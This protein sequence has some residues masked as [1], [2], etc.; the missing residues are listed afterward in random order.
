MKTNQRTDVTAGFCF[1]RRLLAVVAVCCL[2]PQVASAETLLKSAVGEEPPHP[3]AAAE[4]SLTKLTN[5]EPPYPEEVE[6]EEYEWF[7][8]HSLHGEAFNEGPRQAARLMEGVGAIRF[9][10]TSEIPDVQRFIEQGIGQTHGYWY[11][12]AERSFRQAAMLDP[13]CAIAYW[14]MALA[15]ANNSKR[16]KS[17]IAEAVARKEN[18]SEREQ[19]YIDS[20]DGYLNSKKKTKEKSIDYFKAVRKIVDAYPGDLEAKALY[21]YLAYRRRTYVGLSMEEAHDAIGAVLAVEPKHPVHHYRI[22]LWDAK[23]PER[24][25][26]SAARCGQAAPN[27]A[28]MW[29]MPGHI[30][31]RLKRYEDA[32]WQQEASARTDH[33]NMIRDGVMPDEIHNFAHNNE[34]LIRNLI[35]IGRWQDAVSLAVNMT[36]LPRHPKNNKLTG[37]GSASYGRTRLFSVLTEFELWERLIELSDEPALE[38]TEIK[39][40][41]LKRLRHR[42]IAF[43]NL[44]EIAAATQVISELHKMGKPIE[45]EVDALK[46]KEKNPKKPSSALKKKQSELDDYI[47]AIA[48]VEGYLAAGRYEY[49]D[50]AALLKKGK[51]PESAIARCRLLAGDVDGALKAAHSQ[52]TSNQHE[53]I[54]AAH[55]VELLWLAG[56]QSE[57]KQ[58]FEKLREESGSIQMGSPVFDRL[59]PIA[60]ANK[61]PA[62]WIKPSKKAKDLGVRPELNKLGPFRWSPQQAPDWSR[63]NADNQQVSN[64]DYANR[65]VL[66]VFYLGFGCLHCVE[67]LKALS[68]EADKFKEAGIDIVA[69][70]SEDLEG[71]KISLKNYEG[72]MPFPLLADPD[73]S[74]FKK[75]RAY[76]DFEELPLHGAFLIDSAG[77]IRWRDTGHE[78]FMDVKFLLK[79]SKRLLAQSPDPNAEVKIA[80]P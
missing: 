18:A 64:A 74:V 71:L 15:N 67:Q 75:F 45:R 10:V 6:E 69:I 79:E 22:H 2:L 3:I 77:R 43:A 60:I 19:M 58:A 53:V 24:A 48:A 34:W 12:E 73:L 5:E 26:E 38:P 62:K 27:I 33:A 32:V 8:G 11:L 7:E 70:G 51:A 35:H 42:G 25:L 37:R 61:F 9:D 30:Y 21:A 49:R 59:Q 31:S 57:A 76:D 13:D 23:D 66:V 1:S 39:A 68:P 29:H 40:E 17:F 50:A 20:L 47:E 41:Q 36:E 55:E 72:G 4:T 80:K 56:K 52:V 78:P 16:A 44:H 65:P 14:G 46:K 54:P 28:H 63:P